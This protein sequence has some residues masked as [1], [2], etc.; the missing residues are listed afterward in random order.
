MNFEEAMSFINSFSRTGKKVTDLSRIK[1]LLDKIG[2]PQ[3]SLEFVHIAGTNG[4]GSVLEYC[5]EALIKSG[6]KTGQFTS[7]FMECYCD[8]IRIN[9]VNIPEQEIADICETFKDHADAPFSQFE[10]SLA[11]AFLYFKKEKCDVVCLE[12]GVGGRLDATNIIKSP[13]VS[14]ITS[15][16][17]DHTQILGDTVEKI[18]YQKAG[19]IK[20]GCPCVLSAYNEPSVEKL[21]G[22]TAVEN[23]SRLII[24]QSEK[25]KVVSEE[26][27]GTEFIYKD[28]VYRLKMPGFHQVINAV[29]AIETLNIL[30][31]KG[32]DIPDE[33]VNNALKEAFVVSRTE[34]LNLDP[35]VIIDGGHNAAGI[36]SL[37][38]VLKLRKKKRIAGVVGMVKGKDCE[39][40]AERLSEVFE[41]VFCVD[42]FTE[43]AVESSE[44]AKLF[45]CCAKA[46]D[47]A[48]GMKEAMEYAKK[49]SALLVVC[50]SLYLAAAVRSYRDKLKSL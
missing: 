24:P 35:E 36:D 29:T 42:G 11:I 12:T 28:K 9:G 5:S 21:A 49:E 16:S 40:A 41:R 20:K 2:N 19:I 46:S 14:V 47:F 3:D 27:C 4:K 38:N 45:S 8:R 23:D 44:L 22:E 18:A 31:E 25:I 33:C 48:E 34:V 43:N 37:I 50:G 26:L 15:V 13:L 39:Y 7:P 17:L 1:N 6:Y 10:I 32:F 30:R